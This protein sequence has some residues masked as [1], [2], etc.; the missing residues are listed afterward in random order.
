MGIS[1]REN[2][3]CG[4]RTVDDATVGHAVRQT[5]SLRWSPNSSRLE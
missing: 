2:W 1:D 5:A 4:E 3:A